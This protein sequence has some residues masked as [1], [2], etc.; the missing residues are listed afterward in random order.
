MALAGLA[1]KSDGRGGLYTM[2]FYDDQTAEL[3]H[4]L[5]GQMASCIVGRQVMW[6]VRREMERRG[7]GEDGWTPA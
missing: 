3:W 1:T 2:R 5:A 6:R 7:I 4:Q